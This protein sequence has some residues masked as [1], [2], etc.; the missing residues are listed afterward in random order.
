MDF[1][2]VERI[3][4]TAWQIAQHGDMRV[5]AVIY[6]TEEL[7]RTWMTR[8]TSRSSTSRL[9]R[10]RAGGLRDAGCP[11]GLRL[12]DRRRSRFRCGQGRCHLGWGVGFDISCGVRTHLTGLS[13]RAS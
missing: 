2:R 9:A 4:T 8:S 12:S 3:D 6:A 5:P 1:T 7:I 10:H 13:R 11:L